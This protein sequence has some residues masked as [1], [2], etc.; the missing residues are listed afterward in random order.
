MLG[1][2]RSI[3]DPGN[4]EGAMRLLNERFLQVAQTV[5]KGFHTIGH[6]IALKSWTRLVGA[7]TLEVH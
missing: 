4:N 6:T 7:L 5:L 3:S 1:R 2:L